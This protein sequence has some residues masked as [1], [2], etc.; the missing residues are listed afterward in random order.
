[1]FSPKL[2]ASGSDS[3]GDLLTSK[4]ELEIKKQKLSK[5][6]EHVDQSQVKSLGTKV[7]EL[8]GIPVGPTKVSRMKKKKVCSAVDSI[9]IHCTFCSF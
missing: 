5:E 8:P 6:K 7:S 2:G 9:M 1:M 4:E 3:I